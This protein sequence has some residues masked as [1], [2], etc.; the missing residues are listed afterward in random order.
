ATDLA[1][2]TRYYYR[3]GDPAGQTWSA[4]GTFITSDG[5]SD[6]T[7]VDLTDT[8]SQNVT[9]AELSAATMS[10]ALATV[11]NAE[12]MMHNG[13]V[14]E[15]GDVEQDWIDLL[16]AARSSLMSTTIAP[17]AGNHDQAGDA[18]VDH[19]KLE[20]PNGQNTSS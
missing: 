7:F 6:F 19:F 11:P 3:V 12:F 4:T 9:E 1:P 5:E 20:A 17:V 10:K 13:D 15:H 8:Q 14:V 2:D 16:N 18:F